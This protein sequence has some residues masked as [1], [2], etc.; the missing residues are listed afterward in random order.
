[1]KNHYF[2]LLLLIFTSPFALSNNSAELF[3][4][5]SQYSNVKISPTGDYLSAITS[6]EGKNVL[7]VMASDSKK[8]LNTVHFGENAQV[9]DYQWVN[10]ER[11]VLAKEY[12]KGWQDHPIYYGELFAINADG[13]K[14]M[15]LF[16]HNS[17]QMQTGSHIK[18]NT[19]IE[20]T[21]YI[22]D[23]MTHDNKYMLVNAVPW[24]GMSSGGFISLDEFTETKQVVYRVN[25]Y[26]GSRK[27]LT[28]AP[29]GGSR[30]LTNLKGEVK[31]VSGEDK[32]NETKLFYR[33]DGDWID[34]S[35]L[36]INLSEFSPVSF[37]E[38][39]TSIYAVGRNGT[40][41]MGV[42]K[43]N[44]ETGELQKIIQDEKVD[45][46]HFW[47]NNSTQKLYAVEFENGYP[48]YAFVDQD[49]SH[50][51]LLKQL[52][53]SLPGHQ[54]HIV[55]ET[56]DGKKFIIKAFNDRNPG[57][58]YLFDAEKL[59]LEYLVSNK[60]WLDPDLMAEVKPITFTNRNGQTINGYLTVP[61]GKQTKDLPLV[62]N[63][64]GG[65][66]GVRDWWGFDPQNQMLAHE[67]MAVLQ[68]NFRGSGGYGLAF[69]EAGYQQWGSN[70]QYDIIDGTKYLIEQGMADKN[71]ICI[72]GGSFGGYSALQS[73]I[74]AP[75]LF[76]C[77]I[78]FAGIY[79]LELMFNEGD[80]A[81]SRSGTSFLKQ[82]LG[83][84]PSALKAMSP[85]ANVDKL[86]AKLMLVHGGEDKRAP[87]EQLE[88]LER[89]LKAINYPYEKLVM[90]DEGHG[91]YNDSHRAKY[92]QKMLK[93]L[94]DNLDI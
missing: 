53:A 87:I 32:N 83:Q 55:S 88:S 48:T 80:I 71:R 69:E 33:N 57:D 16:G 23:P 25:V 60:S 46:S 36:N 14:S 22:L 28:L 66:H 89:S 6:F 26:T 86:K 85:S 21:A 40:E 52:I 65:P 5:G 42:Y 63:P 1:M 8:L 17:G 2:F 59:K 43:I 19:S 18:K 31:F 54:V 78:G 34:S 94:K 64:H 45:P 77:A 61:N 30:F 27:K 12:L 37:A 93:F 74:L 44:L 4:K 11:I 70:T 51:K 7:V 38:N 49:D 67:G 90:D 47:K 24:A 82:V 15:Y 68:I 91:F 13:S 92:Y 50:S 62:V 81:D 39:D 73:S 75:D 20:A 76:K 79:D 84:N 3:S 41:T 35:K 29:I 9:G 72:V 10:N 56:E 58:F